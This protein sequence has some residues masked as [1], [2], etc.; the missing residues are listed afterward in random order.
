MSE[1]G[2]PRAQFAIIGGSGTNAI[3]F[4]EDF[5]PDYP[6][7][8]VKK[9]NMIFTTPYGESPPFKLFTTGN[10]DVLTVKMHGWRTGV[11]RAQASQQVFWTLQQSGVKKILVEGGVGA[12][13]HLLKPKDLLVPTDYLDFSMRKDVGLDGQYLLI[14][15]NPVCPVM[16]SYLLQSMA[17]NK[18][19]GARI[20]DRG[21][22]AV[23][24]GRHFESRAEIDMLKRAGADIVGQSMCPEV[25]LAR[26]IGACY[27]RLD[28]VVN[29]A[30]G[31]VEDW[32]HKE[33]KEI[34]Y[35]EA[36]KI[37]KILLDTLVLYKE[38]SE[39]SCAE[40]R[41]KTLLRNK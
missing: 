18:P 11:P 37:A 35:G 28:M 17:K 3:N 38:S 9:S 22:Y 5:I 4:P 12:I 21:I 1:Q 8:Q 16:K 32:K 41:K 36:P 2:I 24:D 10:Q 15:R 7:L 20:F 30:E 31:I 19:A 26:E 14:M 13:N 39:C 27:V 34:F 40:L 25:Y 6:G 29:Y 23:T 33:L